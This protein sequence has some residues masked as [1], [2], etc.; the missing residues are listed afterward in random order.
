MRVGGGKTRLFPPLLAAEYADFEQ[1]LSIKAVS[2]GVEEYF[3]DGCRIAVDDDT[4]LILNAGR[5]YGSRIHALRPVHSF[6]IFFRPGLAEQ[7]FSDLRQSTETL[8]PSAKFADRKRLTIRT[9]RSMAPLLN[10]LTAA[11]LTDLWPG[12]FVVQRE[13]LG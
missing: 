7:V 3:V 13:L 2:G 11:R 4:Y 9:Q 6:S 12:A 8:S 5:R 1:L 10:P